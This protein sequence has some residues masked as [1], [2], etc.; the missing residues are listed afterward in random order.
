MNLSFAI[1]FVVWAVTASAAVN[2]SDQPRLPYLDWGACPFECCTYRKWQANTSVTI[3]KSRNQ[4]AEVAFQLKQGEWVSGVTGVV[5]TNQFG[6]SK[7]LKPLEL[8]YRPKD[9][10]PQ[11]SLTPGELVYTLH[12]LGEGFDLFWYKGKT[13]SDQISSR[14]PDPDPPPPELNIQVISLPKYVWWAKIRNK[15]GLIGWTDESNKFN[16]QDACV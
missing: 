11:L 10:K 12:Y 6:V 5:V 7:I 13:Y 3:Y 15:A 16:N 2:S 14:E 8:G 4:N 1:V 9:L